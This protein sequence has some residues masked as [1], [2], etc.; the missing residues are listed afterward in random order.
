MATNYNR[1]RRKSMRGHH[2]ARF[3]AAKFTARMAEKSA[4]GLFRWVTTDHSGLTQAMINMPEMGMIDTL[5]YIFWYFCFG[6]AYS[7]AIGLAVF[8]LVMLSG[9]TF[10]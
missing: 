4:T 9:W 1:Y 8:L 3:G 10:S 2:S 5:K 7:I 6:I